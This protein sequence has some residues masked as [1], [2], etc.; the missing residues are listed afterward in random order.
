MHVL[1]TLLS[2]SS[3]NP[4]HKNWKGHIWRGPNPPNIQNFKF[5]KTRRTWTVL[6]QPWM[7]LSLQC[8]QHRGRTWGKEGVVAKQS[9]RRHPIHQPNV[10]GLGHIQKMKVEKVAKRKQF[11]MPRLERVPR[12]RNKTGN[13]K[14]KSIKRQQRHEQLK[15]TRPNLQMAGTQHCVQELCLLL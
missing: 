10:V 7:M 4:L 15:H 9:K 12:V 5:A 2:R 6:F 11:Y 8:M 3:R 14:P 13:G 1:F